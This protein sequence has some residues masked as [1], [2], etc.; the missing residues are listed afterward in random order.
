LG[1]AVEASPLAAADGLFSDVSPH[2]VFAPTDES[3]PSEPSRLAGVEALTAL[4]REQ[5]LAPASVDARTVSIELRRDE[6]TLTLLVALTASGSDVSISALLAPAEEK[7]PEGADRL[8]RLLAANPALE[9]AAFAYD[10]QR[11]RVTLHR[12]LRNQD[13]SASGLVSELE[14]LADLAA[15]NRNVWSGSGKTQAERSESDKP[16]SEN[17]PQPESAAPST[18]PAKETSSASLVGKWSAVR[19][20]QEAF[21]LRL[22]ANG[23]F[24]LVHVRDGKQN[25][26][27]GKWTLE[28]RTL[29]LRESSGASLGGDMTQP[30]VNEFQFRP[31]GGAALAFK[32][33]S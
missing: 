10:S 11:Q 23:D 33:A 27:S 1:L 25:R 13:L 22:D 31:R 5:G 28:G 32:R 8:L 3:T 15:A 24:F 20:A 7:A 21:A 30:S 12:A 4:L 18:P 16:Q 6:T 29:N 9:N 19:S 26:S 17:K 14:K 2:A